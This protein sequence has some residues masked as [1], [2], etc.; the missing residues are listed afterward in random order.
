[1]HAYK[2]ENVVI[3]GNVKIGEG[4][5]I[6]HNAVIRGDSNKII[7]GGDTNVQDNCVIHVDED[8]PCVIGRNVT[9]GHGA[10]IHGCTIEDNCLIG[11]GSI[12]L[13]GAVI[14]SGSLIGAGSLVSENKVIEE[15]SLAYGSPVK[16]VRELNEEERLEI[17]KNAEKYVLEAE[18]SLDIM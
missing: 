11:M 16:V 3:K 15:H 7:I 18:K 8:H 14:K 6:W 13:N 1:M 12:I 5:N 9:I 4:V 2:G 10:I 17:I